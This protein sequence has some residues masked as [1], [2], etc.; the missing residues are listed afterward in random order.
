MTFAAFMLACWVGVGCTP[1]QDTRGPYETEAACQ[2]RLA[3][4]A[5]DL[6]AVSIQAGHLPPVIQDAR[7]VPVE[8][9]EMT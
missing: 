1:L 5:R 6:T 3:E 4:M 9:G 8:I 2:E 7:C